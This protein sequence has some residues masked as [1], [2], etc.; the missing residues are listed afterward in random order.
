[1]R[2]ELSAVGA[3]VGIRNNDRLLLQ[4]DEGG[5]WVTIDGNTEG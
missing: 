3:V 2:G 4:C 1:M 5:R